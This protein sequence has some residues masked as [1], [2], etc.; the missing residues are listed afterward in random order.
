M[1]RRNR[2]LTPLALVASTTLALAGCASQGADA[3]ASGDRIA[4][5]TSTNVYAQIA[6]EIGGDLV[7][8]TPIVSSTGQDP[9]SFEPSARDQLTVQRADLIIENGGGYDAFVDALIESSGSRRP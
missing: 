3:A 9:H 2:A 7:D 6:E 4:V 1:P 8:A 5:V